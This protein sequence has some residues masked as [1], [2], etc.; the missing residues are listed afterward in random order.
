MLI[1]VLSIRFYASGHG[2]LGSPTALCE[3]GRA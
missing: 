1:A 3:F 2:S